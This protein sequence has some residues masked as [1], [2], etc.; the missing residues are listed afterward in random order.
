MATGQYESGK[1]LLNVPFLWLVKVCV[2]LT[3]VAHSG[4]KRVENDSILNVRYS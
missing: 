1:S 4:S 2:K 3:A